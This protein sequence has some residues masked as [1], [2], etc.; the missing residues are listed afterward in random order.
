MKTKDIKDL[1]I[2]LNSSSN[3]MGKYP[4]GN[5]E[6]TIKTRQLESDGKIWFDAVYSVW[7]IR[8][9]SVDFRRV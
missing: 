9:K 5:K 2:V 1:L 6:L 4:I 8:G 3:N 7:R